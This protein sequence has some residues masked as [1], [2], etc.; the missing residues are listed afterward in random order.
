MKN[1]LVP[2]DFSDNAWNALS[3]A[4]HLYSSTPCNFYLLNVYGMD[5][6]N[7][8]VLSGQS[9]EK[10]ELEGNREKS[11]RLLAEHVEKAKGLNVHS[12][13]R[14]DSIS[15]LEDLL[16]AMQQAVKEHD[17]DLIVMGTKGASNY[18]HKVFGSNAINTMEQLHDCP[19]LSIPLDAEP[20]DINEVVLPTDYQIKYNDAHIRELTGLL[21]N[22]DADLRI[23]HVAD[24]NELDEKERTLQH[25]LK[26]QLGNT[27]YTF[28]HLSGKDVN[29]TVKHFID[30]RESDML[31]FGNKQHS[32]ISKLFST[33]MTVEFGMFSKVPLFVM[34]GN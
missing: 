21:N 16:T 14:F 27:T 9:K 13:T 17:I 10:Y 20:D 34:A 8:S 3:Y 29:E 32:F 23:L 11:H 28:H 31:A 33:N 6:S 22:C 1:I 24:D 7:R 25:F 18:E 12:G 15:I 26:S 4:A 5:F 30:S 2:T 19:I